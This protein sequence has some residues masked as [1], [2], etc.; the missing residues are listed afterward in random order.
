MRKEYHPHPVNPIG[1]LGF[2]SCLSATVKFGKFVVKFLK[3]PPAQP[4]PG[5]ITT[6][7]RVQ[8]RILGPFLA[9]TSYK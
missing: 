3:P 2:L 6:F 9:Y 7:A 1:L 5:V 8:W 4:I